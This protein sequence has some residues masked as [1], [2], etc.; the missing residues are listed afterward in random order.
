MTQ[1]PGGPGPIRQPAKRLMLLL[2]TGADTRIAKVKRIRQSVR[3][4]SY[5]NELKLTVAL[6]R[7]AHDLAG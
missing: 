1:P 7:M 3:T 4:R 6:D 2:K 5:E